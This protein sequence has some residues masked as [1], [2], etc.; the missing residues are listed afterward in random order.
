[1]ILMGISDEAGNSADSQVMALRELGWSRLEVRTVEVPGHSKDNI[2][3]LCDA[4]FEAAARKFS[5]AGIA[6]YCFGS[7]IMNW[8]KSAQ[9]PFEF[10]LIEVR[11][12]IP[13]M[14]RLNTKFVRIMSYRPGDDEFKIPAEVFRRVRDVTNMFL[15]EGIQPLHE[16]CMNYG[17]MSWRHALELLDHCPGLKWAFDPANP[18]FNSDRSK[19]KPWPKQNPWE[20]WKNV[21]DHVAHIHIKDATWNPEKNDADYT[22]PGEGD[23]RVREILKDAIARGYDAALSIEPHMISVFHSTKPKS[24]DDSAM[25]AN[26]VEYGRRLEKMLDEIKGELATKSPERE[27]VPAASR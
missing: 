24:K 3:E 20:F 6:V 8:A 27:P 1:M 22:W 17:G 11:R 14:R 16:N 26:F 15:D 9:T 21:R 4:A 13:R 19:A 12:A 10:T 2:H 18:I 5:E 7:S 25:R 23:G